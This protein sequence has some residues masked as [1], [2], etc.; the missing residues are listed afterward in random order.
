MATT[1][2]HSHGD[3]FNV[4][5]YVTQERIGQIAPSGEYEWAAYISVNG[6]T[7][8]RMRLST[9]DD[10]GQAIRAIDEWNKNRSRR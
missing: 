4:L 5:D 7:I 2:S 1:V 9:H 8:R 6:R 10:A 3:V